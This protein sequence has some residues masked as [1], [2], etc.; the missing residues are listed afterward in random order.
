MHT[1]ARWSSSCARR[2]HAR[3]SSLRNWLLPLVLLLSLRLCPRARVSERLPSPRSH[4]PRVGRRRIMGAA[5]RESAAPVHC[6]VLQTMVL[7]PRSESTWF[8]GWIRG[9][10]S[11]LVPNPTLDFSAPQASPI[12]FRGRDRRNQQNQLSELEAGT[13]EPLVPRRIQKLCNTALRRLMCR[14]MRPNCGRIACAVKLSSSS[15]SA[16]GK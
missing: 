15:D 12:S 5:E 10:G 13:K 3:R 1:A 9:L 11:A 8:I 14:A 2:R 16:V 6:A 4:H 7:V